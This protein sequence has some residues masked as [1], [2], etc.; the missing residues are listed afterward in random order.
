M[1][2]FIIDNVK[3]EIINPEPIA[4]AIAQY[5]VIKKD[6]FVKS[7]DWDEYNS[8]G[9]TI[10]KT[11]YKPEIL[12]LYNHITRT[13]PTGRIGYLID[14][15]WERNL[16]IEI[17]DRR[18]VPAAH[19][20]V[21]Y[22]GPPSDGSN[23]KPAR[24]YQL[25]APQIIREKGGRGILWH[26]TA[27][28]KTFTAARIISDFRVNT[29]YI[30]PSLELLNQTLE[31][32]TEVLKFQQGHVGCIGEGIWDPQPITVAT[33]ATLWT[34]YE[35]PECK[36]LIANTECILLDEC[37]HVSHKSSRPDK[38]K[39]GTVLPVNSWYVIAINCPAYFRVGLTGTPGKDIEQ[40]RSLL[41]CAIGRVVHRVSARELIDM[42]VISDVEVHMHTIKHTRKFSDFN[43]ARKECILQNDKFNEYLVHIAISELKAGKSVLILTSSK[44]EQ[45]PRLVKIFQAYGYDV[46]FVSGDSKKKQRKDARA[47]FKAGRIRAL[48]GTIYKE[49][50][51]FPA[52]DVGILG[53]GGLDEKKV[54]QFLG[55]ILRKAEGKGIAHLHDFMHKDGK[56]LSK[57]SNAR[58]STYVE[59]ELNK[60]IT[61]KGIEV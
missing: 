10:L 1:T 55:R 25:Q 50:V 36:S 45:G 2:K 11:K 38:N 44:A 19:V 43:T 39:S 53:D 57:H 29:L 13:C 37:H 9:K 32:L 8:T 49:G 56:H 40:K 21:E 34:R 52:C 16:P 7:I 35:S 30:V 12:N 51:N 24:L 48:I 33:S 58:M 59:E 4:G 28:G 17:E 41:E 14:W 47:D 42:G 22:I 18:V 15:A 6:S 60:I 31:E 26:A 27:S 54:I 46:P 23:G 5:L 3:T 61:H 20:P